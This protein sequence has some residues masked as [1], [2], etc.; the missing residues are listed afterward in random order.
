MITNHLLLPPQTNQK[1]TDE[2]AM[3]RSPC[4][5]TF[6]DST[7]AKATAELR[8]VS[9]EG[10][11]A[12]PACLVVVVDTHIEPDPQLHAGQRGMTKT[13]CLKVLLHS[14]PTPNEVE[15]RLVSHHEW[16]RL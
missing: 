10:P 4:D 8:V 7:L 5:S 16:M 6:R 3:S 15:H 12:F 14:T 2:V 1:P 11:S 13:S 9:R